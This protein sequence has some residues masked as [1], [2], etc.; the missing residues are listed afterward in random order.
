MKLDFNQL[1]NNINPF[2]KFTNLVKK[3][4]DYSATLVVGFATIYSSLIIYNIF[5]L[6]NNFNR[7]ID[8]AFFLF[9]SLL[10][11]IISGLLSSASILVLLHFSLNKIFYNKLF[12][13]NATGVYSIKKMKSLNKMY[14]S[15]SQLEK[16]IIK[17]NIYNVEQL[18]L[19]SEKYAN[20]NEYE[21]LF[22]I[23]TFFI[24]NVEIDTLIENNKEFENFVINNLKEKERSILLVLYLKGIIQE[25]PD[26]EFLLNNQ[27]HFI[28]L[29]NN[30]ISKKYKIEV[31]K[32]LLDIIK[33]YHEEDN[34]EEE[35][36][37][38]LVEFQN[39]KEK[40]NKLTI[41]KEKKITLI[42]QI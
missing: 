12:F 32:P 40:K 21:G 34:I 41:L 13:K 11:I 29:I 4:K 33:S 39:M 27:D 24:K 19:F 3:I 10:C 37:S 22:Y 15:L 2:K 26:K 5:D 14:S 35:F 28:N 1:K 7:G 38:I 9:I 42:K 30:H 6:F 17:S 16:I 8:V 31:L 25:Y 23:L 20:K 18:E 36:D